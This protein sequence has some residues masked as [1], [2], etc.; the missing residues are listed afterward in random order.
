[1]VEG[2]ENAGVVAGACE[3]GGETNAAVP[4]PSLQASVNLMQLVRI[5]IV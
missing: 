4:A 1:M 2:S 5:R 3:Y